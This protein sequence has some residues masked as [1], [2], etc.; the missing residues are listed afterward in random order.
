MGNTAVVC[1]LAVFECRGLVAGTWEICLTVLEVRSP[2]PKGWHT[3]CL[4]RA[5]R[6]NLSP[7]SPLGLWM[8]IS[9]LS[10]RCLPSSHTCLCV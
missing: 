8:A 3:W 2:K 10:L 4:L 1:G 6:E 7:A 9:G 5:V